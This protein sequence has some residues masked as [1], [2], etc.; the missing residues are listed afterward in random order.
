MT[1]R[2]ELQTAVNIIRLGLK[3]D[4]W[5][6]VS[7]DEHDSAE[8]VESWV[9]QMETALLIPDPGSEPSDDVSSRYLPDD[10]YEPPLLGEGEIVIS[11][12]YK[13]RQRSTG[14]S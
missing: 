13:L 3:N 12:P 10:D 6:D 1:L 14:R 8:E 5:G 7:D 2:T 11:G 9:E 4:Q